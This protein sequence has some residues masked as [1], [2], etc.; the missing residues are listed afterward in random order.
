MRNGI[1]KSLTRSQRNRT[2]GWQQVDSGITNLDRNIFH[3]CA[4][5]DHTHKHNQKI[6]PEETLLQ[7][8]PRDIPPNTPQNPDK[9]K[10]RLSY[11]APQHLSSQSNDEGRLMRTQ[12]N[13]SSY[14]G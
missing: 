3:E 6:P 2:I 8:H 13:D 4:P 9:N 7:T 11:I 12:R 10:P 1:D 14:E 5:A